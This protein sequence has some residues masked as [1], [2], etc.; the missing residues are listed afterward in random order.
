[1]KLFN[2]SIC[3]LLLILSC[4]S[5][6]KPTVVYPTD[7]TKVE[8]DQKLV[9]D[10]TLV[11][12]GELPIFFD[13]TDYLLFPIGPIRVYSRGD[14][15]IYFGSGSSGDK[16]FAIGYLSGTTFTG[17]LD[18][19]MLQHLDSVDFRPFTEQ[20]LKMRSFKFLESIRKKTG[21]QIV[22]LEVTDRDTNGDGKLTDRDVEALYLSR[23]DGTSFTK[24][25]I[26]FHE[27]LDW[28]VLTVNRR[29]Y[30]RTLEDT[31]KNGEFNRKDKIHYYFVKLDQP[32]FKA[33]EYNP[34]NEKNI[35]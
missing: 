28:K 21:S 25:S 19:V 17:N 11:L 2:L 22:L 27:L 15:K 1:M 9:T 4:G 14:S 20:K 29:L 23:L 8:D 18:N 6:P 13:S 7:S 35:L 33:I 34:L 10:T 24:V 5:D 31:D 3:L 12:A 30:F 32:E 26:D 16:S